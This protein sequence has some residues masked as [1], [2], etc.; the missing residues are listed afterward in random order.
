MGVCF[1]G[2]FLCKTQVHLFVGVKSALQPEAG[3]EIRTGVSFRNLYDALF[4]S[5]N[6]FNVS[7]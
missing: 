7:F 3:D 1:R 6:K 5:E 2:L 4:S